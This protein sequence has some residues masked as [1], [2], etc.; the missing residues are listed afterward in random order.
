MPKSMSTFTYEVLAE[1]KAH[2]TPGAAVGAAAENAGRQE[3]DKWVGGN[4]KVEVLVKVSRA[5]IS[6]APLRF[7]EPRGAI[8]IVGHLKG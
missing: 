6:N 5:M 4:S 7:S 1:E 3:I 8:R 2:L